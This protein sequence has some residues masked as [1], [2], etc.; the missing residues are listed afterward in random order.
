M[1]NAPKVTTSGGIK[2]S[3]KTPATN[4]TRVLLAY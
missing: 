3:A 4:T 2:K 1:T